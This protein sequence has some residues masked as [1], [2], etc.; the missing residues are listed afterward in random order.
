[1]TGEALETREGLPEPLRALLK[2][3]PREAWESDPGFSALIRFWLDRHIMFRRILEKLT[4]DT[5]ARLERELA[6]EAYIRHLSH[7]GSLFTRE[8][9]GHH[10]I[11]DQHYFPHLQRLDRRLVRGFDI[12]DRDHHALD[13]HLGTFAEDGNAAIASLRG[14]ELE[15][16]PVMALLHRL[17]DFDRFLNRH[18]TDEEELVVPVLLRYEP[19]GLV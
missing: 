17:K 5:E 18:L 19:P 1:M 15:E 10:M 12:L 4:V 13:S 6:P 8:L 3:Y 16:K 9:H 14:T 7:Y 11:E 2:E